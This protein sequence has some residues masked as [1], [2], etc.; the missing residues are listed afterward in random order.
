MNQSGGTDCRRWPTLAA[1]ATGKRGREGDREEGKGRWTVTSVTAAAIPCVALDSTSATT[2]LPV[3]STCSHARCPSFTMVP[4]VSTCTQSCPSSAL[5]TRMLPVHLH[6][7]LNVARHLQSCPSS[8]PASI[9]HEHL[10]NSCPSLAPTPVISHPRGTPVIP[11]PSS[12]AH[13]TPHH[14][15]PAATLDEHS[16]M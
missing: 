12:P 1:K 3:I 11:P 10:I 2:M 14:I 9:L 6:R 15:P 13:C 16:V 4:V 5:A 7:P 8:P